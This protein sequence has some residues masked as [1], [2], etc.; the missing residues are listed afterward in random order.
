MRWERKVRCS[1]RSVRLAEGRETLA[2]AAAADPG[3]AWVHAALA[4]TYRLEGQSEKALAE[5]ELADQS[6]ATAYTLYVRGQILGTL[7]Q[8]REA[9]D[10]LRQAWILEPSPGIADELSS[11][12]GR[13]GTHA[14]LVESLEIVD[15]A[16]AIDPSAVFLL[17]RRADTL[18]LLG[19]Y[20]E[21]L[22]AADQFL[23]DNRSNDVSGLR[24]LIL[25]DLGRA[26]GALE[27]ADAIL[28]KE[29]GNLFAQYARIEALVVLRRYDEALADTESMLARIPDDFFA[30]VMKATIFCNIGRYAEVPRLL[31]HLLEENPDQP[32]INALAGYALRRTAPPDLPA[33][34]EHMQRA[35]E[36]EPQE[37]WYQVEL[38]DALDE[39]DH[40]DE[41]R[42]IRQRVL[43]QTPT[44]SQ[45]TA[46]R[47]GF[48]GWAA[49][50][51]DRADEA[52]ALLSESVQLDPD[53]LSLRFALALA[54]LHT[55]RDELAIDEYAASLRLASHL[56]SDEYRNALIR[57][58]LSDLRQA[59]E[60]G[61][62]DAIPAA[63]QEAESQ[64]CG[65]LSD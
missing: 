46:R 55:G 2:A 1:P 32:L 4:D 5:L 59:R 22:A 19:H 6:G 29:S 47:L 45:A 58:A 39:L 57:E 10:Q 53:D 28:A 54:L 25:A 31:A 7:G 20:V 56:S 43:D 9:A 48:S 41:A 35:A 13:L 40:V 3:L 61:R 12:L 34:A 36:A 44:G 27:L 63:A 51:I 49:L 14:D 64:L 24:A 16:L 62:L 52:A 23:R 50:F 42:Q 30:R 33:C 15:Q 26:A 38:A 37:P 11:I 65:A 21:A 60:R 8:D 17:A 18:R